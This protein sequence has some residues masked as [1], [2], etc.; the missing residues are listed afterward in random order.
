MLNSKLLK[1]V[2][3]IMTFKRPVAEI[4]YKN[5]ISVSTVQR[6]VRRIKEGENANEKK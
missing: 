3:L 2:K 6:I 5:N 4:A 1:V